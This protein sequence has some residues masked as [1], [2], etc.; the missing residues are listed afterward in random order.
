MVETVPWYY[1]PVTETVAL[2][3][4]TYG[5]NCCHGAIEP[6]W[7]LLAWCYRLMVET[8]AQVL[9]TYNGNCWPVLQTFN[10]NYFWAMPQTYSKNS[11]LYH[12]FMTETLSWRYRLMAETLNLL[13]QWWHIYSSGFVC[14]MRR[15]QAC[16]GASGG[17]KKICLLHEV[18]FLV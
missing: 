16:T 12:G 10:G 4:Q 15:C 9:Q 1:R 3:L 8:I 11:R 5:G 17:Y 13:G 14:S 7:K 18:V 6:W 2:V